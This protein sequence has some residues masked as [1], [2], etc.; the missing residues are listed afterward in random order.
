MK[1][2]KI[3]HGVIGLTKATVGIE[4]V[5]PETLKKRKEIC[6]NCPNIYKEY[7]KLLQKEVQRCKICKCY[8][9]S[10]TSIKSEKCDDKPSRWEA[11]N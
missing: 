3:I 11:E 5:S 1:P 2:N 6:K 10:K 4:I 8:I 9:N 7:S